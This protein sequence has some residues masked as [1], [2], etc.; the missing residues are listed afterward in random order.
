[1]WEAWKFNARRRLPISG[2]YQ[3]GPV[4]QSHPLISTVTTTVNA[5]GPT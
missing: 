5:P 4:T 1:L 2:P 3:L